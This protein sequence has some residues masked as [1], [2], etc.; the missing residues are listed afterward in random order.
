MKK[1][2]G[3]LLFEF[4]VLFVPLRTLIVCMNRCCCKSPKVS[5]TIRCPAVQGFW[6]TGVLRRCSLVKTKMGSDTNAMW[7]G[8]WVLSACNFL[9]LCFNLLKCYKKYKAQRTPQSVNA[10]TETTQ[11]PEY[12]SEL[13]SLSMATPCTCFIPIPFH[14]RGTHSSHPLHLTMIRKVYRLA[15]MNYPHNFDFCVKSAMLLQGHAESNPIY[16]VQINTYP[17]EIS[18]KLHPIR[19]L[20][21]CP[22]ANTSLTRRSRRRRALFRAPCSR[23]PAFSTRGS[24]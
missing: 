5:V 3:V 12:F 6:S 19:V 4:S 13:V 23:S 2:A 8:I 14:I 10:L 17:N 24:T 16:T 20:T 11:T 15:F 9:F 7:I 1:K 18:V 22:N 21:S